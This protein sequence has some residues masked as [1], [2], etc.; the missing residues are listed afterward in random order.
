MTLSR[1]HITM[2]EISVYSVKCGDDVTLQ[3]SIEL[4]K[5]YSW[6]YKD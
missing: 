4:I 3:M 1:D 6:K 2:L 5:E